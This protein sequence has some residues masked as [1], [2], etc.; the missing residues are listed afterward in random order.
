M[1]NKL[2]FSRGLAL[3][4]IVVLLMMPGKGWGQ[5]GMTTTGS[6]TQNFNALATSG[7]T[8]AWTDNST[9]ANW[10]SQRTGTGTTYTADA[11][12]GTAGTLYSYGTGT[13]AERALGT[14]GSSNAAA[15]SFAHGVLLRNTSGNAI[16]DIKVTYTL[17]QWRKSGVTTAQDITFYY[18]ISSSTITSLNPNVNTG[19]TQVTGLTLSSPINTATAAALDGNAAANK[20]TATNVAIPT[21]SLANNDYIMLKWEDPDHTGTDHG[22]SIDDV[23]INWTVTPSNSSSSDIIA[24]T[25][26][27]Y[28]TNIAY[29]SYQSTNIINDANSIEVAKFDIRDGGV[30]TDGDAF[31]TELTAITFSLSNYA[32]VRRL[33]LYDGTTEISE[34]AVSSGTVAFTGL[35]GLTA[36]DGASKIFIVRASFNSTVI[37]NQQFQLTVTSATANAAGSTF[38]AANAGGAASSVTGDNNRIEVTAIKLV[39][40]QQPSNTQKDLAMT[41]NPTAKAEDVNNN[42]DLDYSIAVT[43]TSSGTLTGSP[44]SGSWASN[45]ATFSSLVHTAS[46]T[47][48]ILTAASSGITDATSSAFDITDPQPEINIQE[49]STNYISASTFAFGSVV[50]GNSS[51]VKTFT[52]QNTG[53]ANLTLSGTPKVAISGTN[54]SEFTIDQTATT[55]PV[56]ASG[57]T[58]FTITFSPTSQGAKTAQIIIANNDVTGSEAPYL[59]NLTGTSTVTS[60]SDIATTS[61]YSYTSNVA[62][63]SYQTA[64]TL[65]TGNSV[66]VNGLTIRDGAGSADADN[67]GT[68][69]TAISFTT[70]GSTAIRTAA[71]FEAGTNVKEVAV[72]GATT[73]AFSGLNLVT[74]DGGTKDFDLRVTYNGTVTD[75]QQIT[76][77][78]SSATA[79][80]AGSGFAAG[81]AGGAVSTAT[82]DIN[83]IEVTATVLV[84]GVNPSNVLI[85]AVMSPSPTIVA[86]DGLANFDLDFTGP[87]TMS[88]TGTISG[89]ATNPVSAVGGTATFS[90]LKFSALGTG[91]TIAGTSGSLTTTG[92]SS[93]FNVTVQA[94]GI[95]LSEDNFTAT[96]GVLTANGWTQ[97][98]AIA[99]NPINTGSGNG[100]S[101]TNYGSSNIGNSA[102]MGTAGGQDLYRTFTSQ[103]PGAGSATAYYSCLVNFTSIATGGDYFICFGEASTMGGSATFRARLYAKRGSTASKVLFAIST[104]GTLNYGITEYNTGTPI[105]LVVKH[106]FTSSTSTSSLFINPSVTSEPGTADLT[107]ITASTVATGLDAVV[108]RQGGSASSPGLVVDGIRVGTNWGA[109]LG[110]P[111]YDA[112]SSIAAGNYN[113]VDVLSNTL[114]LTG[115]VAINGTTINN[116]NI[117][118]GAH[119]LS[120]NGALSGSGTYTGGAT[121][122][123]AVGGTG[124]SLSLPAITNGLNNLSITRPN[125][126]TIGATSSL[127]VSGTLTNSAGTSGLVV[128]SGGSLI[129]NSAVSAT[130]KRD[131]AAWGTGALANHGWHFLSSPVTAQAIDPDFTNATPANYDFFAW[132]EPNYEWVNFK[133]TSGTSW[134]TAN[135]LG[136]VGV[137]TD[138]NP[139]QGYLVEYLA[140]GTKQFTGTLNHT[141]ITLSNLSYGSSA[142]KGFHLLGN[143]F[144]SAL[145]WNDGNWGAF[146]NVVATA[147]VWDDATASYLPISANG[148]IPALNGFMVEVTS[149][150]NSIKIP[151][152]SRVHDAA[153]W[154]KTSDGPSIVLVAKD[155]AGQTAQGSFVR[156]EKEATNG[157]DPSFDSHFLAGLAPQ[158]YSVMGNEKLSTNTLPELASETIIPFSFIKNTSTNFSIEAQGLESLGTGATVYLWDNKLGTKHNLSTNPVYTFAS[159]EGDAATRFELHFSTTY[160]IDETATLQQFSIYATNNTVCVAN[161]SATSV[162]GEVFVYNTLGQIIAHQT[163]NGDLTKINIA[164][165]TGYYLVKV[166]TEKTIFVGKVFVKQQ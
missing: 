38:A 164:A 110:N 84:F 26:F 114:S 122:N 108:L 1:K 20:V 154:Y 89:S 141:D 33:A 103:N 66:G 47:G 88:S 132:W 27:T 123:I 46:G 74:T 77:T 34:L 129:Q 37:D 161:T 62:Y 120:I 13:A 140:S 126:I 78:V 58:T 139:G 115:N 135:V 6:H 127:T 149:A 106:V 166:I 91:I 25:S 31:G 153:P 145:T 22:L 76:F 71:L 70:G 57:S 18:K 55:S 143:P 48:L 29:G 96:S 148:I 2:L 134:S 54:L 17:E 146:T 101:F 142:Y 128:N 125:G 133:A 86:L 151:L 111:Q 69:L 28:P 12:S 116:G 118:I 81:N 155:P 44:V 159:T 53:A 138:F 162:K 39:F 36:A 131:V 104:N 73:I 93:A 52:I 64:S 61:G 130:V 15:G 82:G 4:A 79:S 56:T 85:N 5:V 67:L 157:F 30:T 136:G 41:P 59:I 21:L 163:L 121:S 60:T 87:V 10:Y 119:T 117:A 65:T 90:N 99:T 105:L 14:I 42:T 147:K 137:T 80:A 97:I 8:N 113:D 124:A 107:D 156:F 112:A 152:A 3:V 51:S 95:L 160:G 75:N 98:G 94:A 16:T 63:A 35:T 7:S 50:S 100:L 92:N 43:V 19:W 165:T 144:T 45:V 72:N 32:N 24:N 9:I 150:T 40:I 68:S 158:F 11:G 23:T 49:S 102:I 109:V 83:R